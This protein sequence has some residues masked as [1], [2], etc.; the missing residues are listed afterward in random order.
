M[1]LDKPA[2][3]ISPNALRHAICTMLAPA[4]LLGGCASYT[5]ALV[6]TE[7]AAASTA[8]A[9][10]AGVTMYLEEYGSKDRAAK[11]FDANLVEDGVLPIFITLVNES[12][13]TLIVDPMEITLRDET[14][15]LKQLSVDEAVTKTKKNAWG[16]A[17][18]WSMIVPIISIPIAATASVMHTNKVNRQRFEDFTAKALVGAPL[19]ASKE[20][21]GFLFF[22]VDKVR[23]K[24]TG[25]TLELKAKFDGAAGGV[26]ISASVPTVSLVSVAEAGKTEEAAKIDKGDAPAPAKQ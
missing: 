11:A 20:V 2:I 22:E 17:L 12:G 8:K 3:I 13:K 16:R 7:T 25:I 14:G 26:V 19:P 5:P 15:L 6:K 21:S 9:A 1:Y 10:Q 4:L 23:S 24:W 18:G